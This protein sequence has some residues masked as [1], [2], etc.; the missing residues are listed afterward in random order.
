MSVGRNGVTDQQQPASFAILIGN[1]PSQRPPDAQARAA[2]GANA[3]EGANWRGQV[4][5]NHWRIH[6]IRRQK[7][8]SGPRTP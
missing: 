4:L 3:D 8:V 5:G 1:A 2:I 7:A 6:E